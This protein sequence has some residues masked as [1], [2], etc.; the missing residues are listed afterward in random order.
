MIDERR[1]NNYAKPLPPEENPLASLSPEAIEFWL[2]PAR[3]EVPKGTDRA[4]MNEVGEV[5]PE[6]DLMKWAEWMQLADRHIA[7][8]VTD[9]YRVST[10]FLGLDHGF[11]GPSRWFETMVFDDKATNDPDMAKRGVDLFCQRYGT[12]IEASAGH[13]EVVARIK[14][15]WK[16]SYDDG[17][18]K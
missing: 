11:G 13:A 18:P 5:A 9:G 17:E 6:P 12:V 10:V 4:I 7:N 2:G 1:F 15:G 3:G 16:P 14:L 8:T